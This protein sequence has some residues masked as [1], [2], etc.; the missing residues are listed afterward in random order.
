MAT[1]AREVKADEQ[2]VA[3][4]HTLRVVM[5]LMVIPLWLGLTGHAGGTLPAAAPPARWISS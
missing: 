1:L 4:I 2:S 5:V 3:V